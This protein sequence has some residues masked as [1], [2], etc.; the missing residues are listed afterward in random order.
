MANQN[1]TAHQ[2]G[3]DDDLEA[4]LAA[5]MLKIEGGE[6]PE[7]DDEIDPEVLSAVKEADQ[8]ADRQR[9]AQGRFVA[10][11]AAEAEPKPDEQDA[12]QDGVQQP[13]GKQD[14]PAAQQQ[15]DMRPPPGYSP[16]SKAAWNDLPQAVRADIA[17]REAEMDRG[18]K[19]YAGCGA[20]AEEAERSGTTLGEYVTRVRAFD[21][22][23]QSDFMGG[24]EAVCKQFGVQP[25]SL[26]QAI[27]ARYGDAPM[28]PGRDQHQGF[29]QPPIDPNAI[30]QQ[31]L[32]S[33]RQEFENREITS[34]I[35]RFAADPKHKFYSNVE[36]IM[37]SFVRQVKAAEPHL[38]RYQA[39]EKAYESACWAHPEI[40]PIL[41]NEQAASK[42]T[43]IQRQAQAASQARAASK[44]ITG[45]PSPGARPVR[46]STSIEDDL[47]AAWD[48]AAGGV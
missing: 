47:R 18:M 19:R 2:G 11:Q 30:V 33:V 32:A 7:S 25:V 35:E 42:A 23:L 37:P 12:S 40:R 43:Q 48:D 4:L 36:D 3:D 16:A 29:Q 1:E 41:L 8:Q 10:K 21:K 6:P 45:A 9:D 46:A 26:A 15:P 27:S 39:L 28:H 34:D 13:D 20:V 22:L 44:S 31:A 17:K 38:S 24:I 14:D 5:E